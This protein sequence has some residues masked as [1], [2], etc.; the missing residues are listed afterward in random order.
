ML[1]YIYICMYIHNIIDFCVI[2]VIV[3]STFFIYVHTH[4]SMYTSCFRFYSFSIDPYI[5]SDDSIKR[6]YSKFH[7]VYYCIFELRSTVRSSTFRDT[8]PSNWRWLLCF[9]S[10]FSFPNVGCRT[11]KL[12]NAIAINPNCKGPFSLGVNRVSRMIL[13]SYLRAV[14]WTH[15]DLHLIFSHFTSGKQLVVFAVVSLRPVYRFF[16]CVTLS[17]WAYEY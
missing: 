5:L 3:K 13:K 4:I 8:I 14:L 15:A 11:E 17:T 12:C 2:L 7:F 1:H 9:L 6:K 16:P 10:L